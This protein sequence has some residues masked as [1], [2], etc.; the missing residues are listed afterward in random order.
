MILEFNRE[1]IFAGL[2][3]IFMLIRYVFYF[4][5]IYKGETRPHGFSWFVWGVVVGIGALAQ[6]QLDPTG[7]SGWTLLAVAISC[8]II[9]VLGFW[10]GEKNIT[11]GDWITF[12]SALIA[13]PVWQLTQEP[14]LA[15]VIVMTIDILSYYPTMRKTWNEP[16]TEPALSTFTCAARYFC[17]MF[18]V[19]EPT[20]SNLI[21]PGFLMTIDLIFALLIVYRRIVLTK[22]NA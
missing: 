15:V 13:I 7:L 22:V 12:L 21:Y 2:A 1:T 11:R 3:L 18:T 9:A 5:S 19:S 16:W 8:L 10:I 20:L 17:I 6:L 14:V 4:T